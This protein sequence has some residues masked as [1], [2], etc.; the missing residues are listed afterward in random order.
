MQQ[1]LRRNGRKHYGTSSSRERHDHARRQSSN[2]AIA[3][4]ARAA[5]PGVGHH[6]ARIYHPL[7]SSIGETGDMLDARLRTGNVGTADG[8]LDVILDVVDRA[9]KSF[10]GSI[11]DECRMTSA[12]RAPD[13]CNPLHVTRPCASVW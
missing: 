2:T 6:N 8:A 3:S 5:E 10:W 13:D 12:I 1:S 7:I 4:F 11:G 9:R